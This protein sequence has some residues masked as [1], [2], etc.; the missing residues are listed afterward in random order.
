[1]IWPIDHSTAIEHERLPVVFVTYTSC[2]VRDRSVIENFQTIP[3][4][5]RG[6][7]MKPLF[8]QN[9]FVVQLPDVSH[10]VSSDP[11]HPTPPVDATKPFFQKTPFI[12]HFMSR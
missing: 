6:L 2:V 9:G 12:L 5:M 11:P 7:Q 3:G 10:T 1:M 4:T 8:H